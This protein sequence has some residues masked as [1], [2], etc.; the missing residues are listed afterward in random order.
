VE[1]APESNVS[2]AVRS[3]LMENGQRMSRSPV[4]LAAAILIAQACA[5]PGAEDAAHPRRGDFKDGHK[6]PRTGA[7]IMR[8]RMRTPGALPEKKTLGLIVAFHGLN[9][10]E[11]SITGFAID[12]ARRVRIADEYVIT[13]GKSKGNGWDRADDKDVLAWIEWVLATYPIDRR[14]VHIVGMSNGGGMV[15]RFGWAN[16]DI[17]ASVSS[18]CGVMEAFSGAAR[19]PKGLPQGGPASPAETKTEWY[20]VHGDADT[21]VG[22]EASRLAAKQLALKGYRCVYREIDGGDHVS[23]LR[24][25]EVVDDNFRFIHALRH[26]EVPLS[27][28][29]SGGLASIAS[30]LKSEKGEAAGPLIAEAARLGGPAGAAAI[31]NALGNPDPAVKKAAIA[32]AGS[33]IFG[34]D[35]ALALV[36]LA[37]DKS[38]EVKAAAFQG[39]AALANWRVAEARAFLVQAARKGPVEDRVA[40][41]KGLGSVVKPMFLG[42]YEDKEVPWTLVLLLEDK[43]ARVRE[44]AFAALEAGAKDTFGY[45]PDLAAAERKAASA[46]WRSWCEKEAGPFQG[47]AAR[48]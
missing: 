22:V 38:A 9:G 3:T 19:S 4:T 42:W 14:R 37:K 15:K 8:Y 6:D 34:R 20:L 31:K 26:K 1:I 47:P 39:L 46:K 2:V 25:T 13:G 16:Q 21:T 35:V 32:A 18:Y 43:E 29:E 28:E 41:V 23:I 5:A 30:R 24:S 40:A 48:P 11:D 44:A 12:A 17:F 33:V 36:K 27:K 45:K 10:D 7:L